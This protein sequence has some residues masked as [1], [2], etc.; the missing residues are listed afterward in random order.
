MGSASSPDTARNVPTKRAAG[1]RHLPFARVGSW[2][3]K[4]GSRLPANGSRR[5]Q[6]SPRARG[7][8]S[9]GC[10]RRMPMRQACRPSQRRLPVALSSRYVQRFARKAKRPGCPIGARQSTPHSTLGVGAGPSGT[11]AK[12]LEGRRPTV[13]GHHG[14]HTHGGRRIRRRPAPPLCTATKTQSFLTPEFQ[15]QRSSGLRRSPGDR[16]VGKPPGGRSRAPC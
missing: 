15:E 4:N 5:V 6:K 2:Q 11:P 14:G 12:R 3:I 1:S 7:E 9:K 10:R 13:A 16:L 8:L